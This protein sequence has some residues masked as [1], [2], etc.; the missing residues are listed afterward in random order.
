M[1]IPTRSGASKQRLALDSP[2]ERASRQQAIEDLA[3]QGGKR[4]ALFLRDMYYP[5]GAPLTPEQRKRLHEERRTLLK[6][7][8]RFR[9]FLAELGQT[10]GGGFA[11]ARNLRRASRVPFAFFSRKGTLEDAIDGYEQ[12]AVAVIKKPDPSPSGEAADLDYE[13][14]RT[15]R[16]AAN[17]TAGHIERAIQ[18]TSWRRR[19][20]SWIAGMFG[21][22]IGVASSEAATLLHKL[23]GRLWR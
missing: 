21:F 15:A 13:Y 5:E 1:M 3:A 14:D 18:R 17:L 23:I 19:H 22:L 2:L 6:A 8:S 10:A 9:E 7:Q 12:G 20:A 4:P 11:L 16:E